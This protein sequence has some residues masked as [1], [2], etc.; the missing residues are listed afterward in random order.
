MK[1]KGIRVGEDRVLSVHQAF[2]ALYG[3]L[4][5]HWKRDVYENITIVLVHKPYLRRFLEIK[6]AYLRDAKYSCVVVLE[7]AT[8]F[9]AEY[10]AIEVMASYIGV[11]IQEDQKLKEVM[12]DVLVGFWDEADENTAE[13]VLSAIAMW[14]SEDEEVHR[15]VG[16]RAASMCEEIDRV[17]RGSY[18]PAIIH[19][20]VVM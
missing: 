2:N 7:S 17:L 11:L 5:N 6:A 18:V 10:A 15:Q 9:D 3:T 1:I 8:R 12:N 20:L 19:G 14:L 4:S 16:R 13:A